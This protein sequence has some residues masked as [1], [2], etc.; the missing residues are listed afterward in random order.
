MLE[1]QSVLPAGGP[2]FDNSSGS[3]GIGLGFLDNVEFNIELMRWVETM[4]GAEGGPIL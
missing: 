2:A 4:N 3:E 1:G